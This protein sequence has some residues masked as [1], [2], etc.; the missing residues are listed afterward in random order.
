MRR[1]KCT[2]KNVDCARLPRHIILTSTETNTK[3][4]KEVTRTNNHKINS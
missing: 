1:P 4:K 2:K 3:Y